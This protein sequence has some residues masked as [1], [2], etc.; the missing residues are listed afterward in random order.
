MFLLNV[1]LNLEI[2]TGQQYEQENE[3]KKTSYFINSFPINHKFS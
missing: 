1:D 2:I 3:T